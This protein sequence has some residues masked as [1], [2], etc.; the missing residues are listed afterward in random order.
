MAYDVEKNADVFYKEV[1]DGVRSLA[2]GRIHSQ[3]DPL[4]V[5]GGH[6]SIQVRMSRRS[7]VTCLGHDASC[8]MT[9]I[10]WT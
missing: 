7:K 1:P 10:L 8:L 9:P 6:C 2:F 3:P 4:A 5:V